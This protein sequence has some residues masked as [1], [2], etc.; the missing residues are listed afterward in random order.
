MNIHGEGFITDASLVDCSS[1]VCLSVHDKS[2]FSSQ[3]IHLLS[4]SGDLGIS[5]V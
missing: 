3:C 5:L 4:P 2:V 1:C